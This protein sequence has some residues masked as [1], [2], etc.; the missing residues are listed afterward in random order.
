MSGSWVGSP[1]WMTGGRPDWADD[2]LGDC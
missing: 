2:L 1:S